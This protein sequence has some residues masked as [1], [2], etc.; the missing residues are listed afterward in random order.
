MS[1]ILNQSQAKAVYD[2]MVALNNINSSIG[3][4]FIPHPKAG[5]AL[6]V[7]SSPNTQTVSV[8]EWAGPHRMVQERYPSQ[9]AF[10]TAYNLNPD[11]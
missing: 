9:N 11:G 5:H 8:S 7:N 3:S 10:A 2:A 6:V 4:V 1:K